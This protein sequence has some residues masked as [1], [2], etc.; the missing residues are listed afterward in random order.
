LSY[1]GPPG[2]TSVQ[3]P[4]SDSCLN[5]PWGL[6]PQAMCPNTAFSYWFSAAGEENHTR[7]RLCWTSY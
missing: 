7:G 2:Y 4:R 1:G 5:T 6:L 3:Y